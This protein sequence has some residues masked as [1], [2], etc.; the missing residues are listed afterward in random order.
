M[1]AQLYVLSKRQEEAVKKLSVSIE[2]KKTVPALRLL[3]AIREQGKDFSAARDAYEALL[4]ISNDFVPAINN[5]AVIYA[6]RLGQLD[7]ALDLARRAREL[8]PSDP[9]IA[10]TLG[11]ILF[12]RGEFS[13]A[14]QLLNESVGKLSG[15]PEI[16]FHLG[17]AYYM[18]GDEQLARDALRRAADAAVD[19]PGQ[20]DARARLALLAIDVGTANDAGRAELKEYLIPNPTDQNPCAHCR[21]PM[22]MMR[23]G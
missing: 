3:A 1:L 16:Q 7:K 15:N 19:F 22:D 13:Q 20:A 6:E 8:N 2:K 12:R 21:N 18:M 5:L 10:D 9:N 11:W 17:M 4:S 14:P 23:Q